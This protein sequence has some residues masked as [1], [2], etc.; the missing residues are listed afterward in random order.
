MAFQVRLVN[1][2]QSLV[3]KI[4]EIYRNSFF[5]LVSSDTGVMRTTVRQ[6]ELY[7]VYL[8][9]GPKLEISRD[10][11]GGIR[12]VAY[13]DDS[14]DEKIAEF[15]WVPLRPIT[16]DRKLERGP[17]GRALG[18]SC[19]PRSRRSVNVPGR[20]GTG[21]SRGGAASVRISYP[22]PAFLE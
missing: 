11:E 13:L 18:G 15:H 9:E 2:G 20:Y 5:L 21:M 19:S 16:V 7:L 6:S 14:G 10:A 17:C 1:I 22:A 8:D 4:S 3:L 12:V